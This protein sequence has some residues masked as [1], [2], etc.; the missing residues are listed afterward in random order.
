MPKT[1]VVFY[2]D[3]DGSVPALEWLRDGR[4]VPQKALAKLRVLIAKL[5]E[6]G[7]DLRRPDAA[8]L[9]NEIYE[10]RARHLNVHYRLLYFFHAR[11]KPAQDETNTAAVIALGLTK[12]SVVPPVLINRAVRYKARFNAQPAAHTYDP[13][14]D[15][16]DDDEE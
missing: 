6:K 1:D 11:P 3:D 2:R 15:G 7:R 10:L 16:G 5:A 13:N 4:Q 8:L 14:D 12:E 9:R